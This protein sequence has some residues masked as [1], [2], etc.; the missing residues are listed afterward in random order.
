MSGMKRLEDRLHEFWQQKETRKTW[1]E[2]TQWLANVGC[3][4]VFSQPFDLPPDKRISYA[5]W[6]GYCESVL[7]H[8]PAWFGK[9]N[10]P[11][12][13]Y[14]QRI[15]VLASPPSAEG[16]DASAHIQSL[17]EEVLR[18]SE[19][20][21]IARQ[22]ASVPPPQNY[23]QPP[24]YPQQAPP[25]YGGISSEVASFA[26][27]PAYQQPVYQQPA[28]QYVPQPAAPQYVPQAPIT[29]VDTGTWM[30]RE[31]QTH[32]TAAESKTPPP[33]PDKVPLSS[34][35]LSFNN[36][37]DKFTNC[38]LDLQVL[39][40]SEIQVPS[41]HKISYRQFQFRITRKV[42]ASPELDQ[43]FRQ[44]ADIHTKGIVTEPLFKESEPETIA[45]E[46]FAL[47]SPVPNVN[48]EPSHI[49]TAEELHDFSKSNYE[50]FQA[51]PAE[52]SPSAETPPPVSAFQTPSEDLYQGF[53]TWLDW[54]QEQGFDLSNFSSKSLRVESSHRISF[55]QFCRRVERRLD[56]TEEFR[57]FINK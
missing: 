11:G 56:S 33:P 52:A 43:M 48:N 20:L 1:D 29:P 31:M 22:Q 15:T 30:M 34:A 44:F 53:N 19:E 12:W 2:W 37:C 25:A 46:S 4:L 6:L 36:W 5:A 17:Q 27:Q 8:Y 42:G 32:P 18:L 45:Q 28:P 13:L 24:A 51:A 39:S 9:L 21:R 35:Y 10:S 50:D 41:S 7:V 47:D 14:S 55:R 3:E 49:L 23:A 57:D 16:D 26:Q 40:S 54:F 38:N